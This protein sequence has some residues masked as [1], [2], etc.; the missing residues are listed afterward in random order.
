[1][2]GLRDFEF[3]RGGKH[4]RVEKQGE[5]YWPVFQGTT[6][7]DRI[8]INLASASNE[9]LETLATQVADSYLAGKTPLFP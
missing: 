5:T 9:E 1:M 8:P 4:F 6:V 3:D 2:K 7:I